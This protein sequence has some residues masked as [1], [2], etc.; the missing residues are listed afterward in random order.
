MRSKHFASK[1]ILLSAVAAIGFAAVSLMSWQTGLQSARLLTAIQHGF[2]AALDTKIDAR[3]ALLSAERHLKSAVITGNEEDLTHA[4]AWL[5]GIASKFDDYNDFL[6]RR[7]RHNEQAQLDTVL[8]QLNY[9]RPPKEEL[10]QFQAMFNSYR[11]LSLKT[12]PLLLQGDNSDQSLADLEEMGLQFS[13]IQKFL[14]YTIER[15]RKGVKL[16]FDAA[17]AAQ[18]RATTQI[19]GVIGV[20]VLVLVVIST[21]VIR[22]TTRAVN[23]ARTGMEGLARGY[24]QTIA[25]TPDRDELGQMVNAVNDVTDTL[26]SLTGEV[27]GLVDAVQAG[28]LSRRGDVSRFHGAYAELVRNVNELIDAFVQPIEVTAQYVENIADGNIPAPVDEQYPGDFDRTRRNLN[29]LV[30]AMNCLVTQTNGLTSA[31]QA[32]QL[33][34]RG[35]PQ[36][37]HGAW[38]KLIVGIN[39]TL[40]AV[41]GPI[42][43]V[44]HAMSAIAEG[45]L[46]RHIAGQ[47]RGQFAQLASDANATGDR[48]NTVISTISETATSINVGI[49]EIASGNNSLSARTELQASSLNETVA[50]IDALTGAIRENA[51]SAQ[52]ATTMAV[53]ARDHAQKGGEV[54]AH[55]ISAMSVLND[56]SK[57]VEAISNVIDEIAFQT[58]L[59]ALNAAVEAARAGEQGKGFAVVASE[60]RQLA[61]RSAKAAREIKGL[62]EESMKAM[63][64]ST[65]MVSNSGTTLN[66]IIQA[67]Q[68]VV[69]HITEISAAGQAQKISAEGVSGMVTRLDEVTQQNAALVEE[70]AAASELMG[71]QVTDLTRHIDFFQVSQT[72]SVADL[73]QP[74]TPQRLAG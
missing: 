47:Y 45:Q 25:A 22:R 61:Q 46:G 21:L 9:I 36:Q 28:E 43:D 40:D 7:E 58:N 64:E 44:S 50:N 49:M 8:A 17:S 33:Q 30:D 3:N 2:Y 39:D 38:R 4:R 70:M 23:T 37:L 18:Q 15:D 53:A 52:R 68:Q 29:I 66:E 26:G 31:A 51:D 32:G 1:I 42:D 73:T 41:T 13:A 57:R 67:V 60:V 69:E 65:T 34:T 24:L 19:M 27:T 72:I 11:T 35:D 62:I 20:C 56:S 5:D 10:A 74:S 63:R 12:I 54:V 6:T 71:R 14:D 48:L 55:A 59:L 16:A